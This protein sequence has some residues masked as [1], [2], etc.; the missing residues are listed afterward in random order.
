MPVN[1]RQWILPF[2][3]V[4]TVPAAGAARLVSAGVNVTEN[5]YRIDAVMT[6]NAELE[7]VKRIVTD[8]GRFAE[9]SPSVVRSRVIS[10]R[11]GRDARIEVMFRPCV[12]VIFC[13]TITKVSDVRIEPD[14]RRMRYLTVPR[15]SDFHQ[16]IETVTLTDHSEGGTPRV[17]F[18]YSA[19]LTPKFFV[20]PFV[21]AWLIR[22]QIA[23]D[24]KASGLRVERILR[25]E[26]TN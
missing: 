9:L 14:G 7:P 11:T 5:H 26:K 10:G 17:R 25:D 22:R 6:L 19:M 16:G 13:R 24:L 18:E 15:L 21:G 8:Y 2:L 1:M 12:L 3:F 20:P 4:A 23:A